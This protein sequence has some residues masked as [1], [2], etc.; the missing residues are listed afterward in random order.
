MD[1]NGNV[2][3]VGAGSTTI[4]AA[5]APAANYMHLIMQP[6]SISVAKATPTLVSL[7]F[8]EKHLVNLDRHYSIDE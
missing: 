5:Q 8:L 3:I 6:T 7:V 2:T 4:R 1:A